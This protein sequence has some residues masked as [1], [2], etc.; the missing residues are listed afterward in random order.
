MCNLKNGTLNF[1]E[2]SMLH[3]FYIQ[4]ET[5][6]WSLHLHAYLCVDSICNLRVY[7]QKVHISCDK[8]L[9]N[10]ASVIFEYI[11]SHLL[12]ETIMLAYVII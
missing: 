12:L 1:F 7:I 2:A 4:I 3:K 10:V 11:F 9:Y 5:K 8:I 6:S